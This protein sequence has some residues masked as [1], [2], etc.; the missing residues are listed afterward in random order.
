[1]PRHVTLS[2]PNG[3]AHQRCCPA[4]TRQR[5]ADELTPPA[6]SALARI[7][8]STLSGAGSV[9]PRVSEPRESDSAPIPADEG[10]LS[11]ERQSRVEAGS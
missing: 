6:A 10:D 2:R 7:G 1:M 4:S 5:L 8:S 11:R 3:V 9:M